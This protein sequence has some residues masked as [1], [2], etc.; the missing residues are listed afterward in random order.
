MGMIGRIKGTRLLFEVGQSTEGSSTS[1]S[2]MF[3]L[4]RSWF[5]SSIRK[6]S[7]YKAASLPSTIATSVED[8]DA[9]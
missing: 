7:D 5:R 4:H 6:N 8:N 9:P 2:S 1:R 3:K